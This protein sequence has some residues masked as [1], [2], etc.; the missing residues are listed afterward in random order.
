MTTRITPEV[1]KRSQEIGQKIKQGRKLKGATQEQLG[2]AL[3][4]TFQQI[5]KYE[6]GA[7]RVSVPCMEMI[8]KALD[9]PMSFFTGDDRVFEIPKQAQ[10]LWQH[11]N[12][13]PGEAARQNILTIMKTFA[14]IGENQ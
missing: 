1:R 13:L 6:K 14:E 12:A 9:L 11:Y 8:C 7:D 10:T 2:Q 4:V 5:Q 3:G